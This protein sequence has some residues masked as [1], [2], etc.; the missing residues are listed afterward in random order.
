MYRVFHNLEKLR[1]MLFA[2]CTWLLG[3]GLIAK[4]FV[5]GLGTTVVFVP[6]HAK[7]VAILGLILAA[8]SEF[9]QWLSDLWKSAAH[10]LHRELDFE[11]S[12][13]WKIT[14]REMKDFL[15]RYAG[16]IESF[17][18]PSEKN[19]FASDEQ[20]GPK[21]ALE[22]LLESASWSMHLSES[23]WWIFVTAIVLI[24]LGCLFL[25][26]VSVQDVSQTATQVASQGSNTSPLS[27]AVSVTVVKVVTSTVLF[28][29]SY[30]LFKFAT[31]YLSFRNKSRQIAD[32]AE[33]LLENGPIDEVQAIKL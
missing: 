26:N 9:L 25:L 13:G 21:R 4:F 12:F 20:P 24:L 16:D 30:G 7:L 32:T 15:A 1:D 3:A 11:N 6:V 28:I 19:F 27:P 10:Q 22:N 31:G 5:F 8:I 29:F 18:G 23:M 33:G 2:R 14:D 17:T